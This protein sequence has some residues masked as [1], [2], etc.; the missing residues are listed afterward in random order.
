M[1]ATRSLLDHIMPKEGREDSASRLPVIFRPVWNM[2]RLR[3][4]ERAGKSKSFMPSKS[5][6]I[7]ACWHH[8]ANRSSGQL[9][10]PVAL[11]ELAKSPR[12]RIRA[13]PTWCTSGHPFVEGHFIASLPGNAP[14]LTDLCRQNYKTEL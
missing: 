6:I 2:Q 11:S 12:S 8:C 1:G 13:G 4:N 5:V 14:K 3:M 7:Q 9:A 10:F